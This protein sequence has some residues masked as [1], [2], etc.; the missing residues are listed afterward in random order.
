MVG[1]NEIDLDAQWA[2]FDA[3]MKSL[4]DNVAK[5]PKVTKQQQGIVVRKPSP[6]RREDEPGPGIAYSP[7]ERAPSVTGYGGFDAR[8]ITT[9]TRPPSYRNIGGSY[10]DLLANIRKY[11]EAAVAHMTGQGYEVHWKREN[12]GNLRPAQWEKQ[13]GGTWNETIPKTKQFTMFPSAEAGLQA[14]GQRLK[15]ATGKVRDFIKTY[16]PQAENDVKQYLHAVASGA[17]PLENLPLSDPQRAAMLA[18]QIRH[19]GTIANITAPSGEITIKTRG[20]TQVIPPAPVPPPRP[21][22]PVLPNPVTQ[23]V[24]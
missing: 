12:P 22:P 19:E 10:D 2:E 14:M 1:L 20:Q 13:F 9:P 17:S 23:T 7:K 5:T 6:A 11:G 24:Q 18:V 21:P 8:G 16:A 3:A 4:A 15:M